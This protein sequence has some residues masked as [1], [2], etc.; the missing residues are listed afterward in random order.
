M[1]ENMCMGFKLAQCATLMIVSDR[2]RGEWGIVDVDDTVE[3]VKQVVKQGLIDENRVV[4]RGGSAGSR[5]YLR[6]FVL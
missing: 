4:I 2:L 3:C 1:A 6:S 5:V